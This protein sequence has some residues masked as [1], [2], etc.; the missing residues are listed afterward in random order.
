MTSDALEALLA[1]NERFVA[2]ERIHPRLTEK[3]EALANH[4]NPF[5]VV[6][7]CSDSRVPPELVFDCG[8]GALFVIRVAGNF[9]DPIGIGSIEYAVAHFGS[10]LLLV[11]GH[12]GCGAI[13]ATVDSLRGHGGR[14][15]GHIADIVDALTPATKIALEQPG[16]PYANA[17][18]ENVRETAKRLQEAAPILSAAVASHA[19]RVVGGVYDLKSGRVAIL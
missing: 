16:D 19:L 8:L 1:G 15:P 5:A 10:P 12:S 18:A 9:A 3:R 13:T 14:A 7:S 6:L 17:V 2:G 11:M 4:Q